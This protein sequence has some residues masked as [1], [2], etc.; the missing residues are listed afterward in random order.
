MRRVKEIQGMF[1]EYK[2]NV[3]Q[4]LR[5]FTDLVTG[6][7]REE[8]IKWKNN[9]DISDPGI[10]WEGKLVM[11]IHLDNIHSQYTICR[12]EDVKQIFDKYLALKRVDGLK[13]QAK[14]VITPLLKKPEDIDKV[15]KLTDD[16][17]DWV[18]NAKKED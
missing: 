9:K 18:A 11:A 4:S 5:V 15:N 16:L 2:E 8:F 12:M 10:N 1:D 6:E 14:D 13:Q 3:S 17:I 7:N